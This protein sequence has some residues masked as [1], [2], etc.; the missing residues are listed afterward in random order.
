LC[1]KVDKTLCINV[2]PIFPIFGLLS[3]VLSSTQD[4]TAD[5]LL[6][7]VPIQEGWKVARHKETLMQLRVL[8]GG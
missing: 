6:C 8:G 5:V 2:I 4:L 7:C 3:C 1:C